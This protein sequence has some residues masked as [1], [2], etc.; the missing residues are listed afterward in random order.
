MQCRVV[1][2]RL[3]NPFGALFAILFAAVLCACNGNDLSRGDEAL[4]IGDYERAVMNFSKV[5]DLEPANRDARYGLAIAYYAIAEDKER[6]K[7]STLSYWERTVREFKILSV[8]DTGEKS[9]PM[10]STSLFYLARA[11]LAE[12]AQAKVMS[13]LDKSIQLDPENYFSYNLKALI[14]AGQ[15]DTEGAKK[16]YAYIVTKQPKFASAYVNLGNLYWNVHDYESAWD[17]WSMGHEALP[18]D[19]V[20]AKWTRVAED[21]LKAMVYSGKL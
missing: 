8:V 7:E 10:Y 12:N 18:E 14:L 21:S 1:Q 19:A 9:K 16:I 5:L 4:R 2:N 20:L 17:I 3:F 11:K 6:L 13:L 15:G